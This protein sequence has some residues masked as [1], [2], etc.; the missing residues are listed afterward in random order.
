MKRKFE[1]LFVGQA[2]FKTVWRTAWAT[3]VV[4]AVAAC[5]GGGGKPIMYVCIETSNEN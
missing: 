3:V 4:G 5:G 1:T 2:L